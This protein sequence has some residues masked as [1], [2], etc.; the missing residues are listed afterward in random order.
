MLYLV[1]L[2]YQIVNMVYYMTE[3]SSEQLERNRDRSLGRL[4][5]KLERKFTQ[6]VIEA[7]EARGIRD[8]K[9][10]HIPVL[11]HIDASGSRAVEVAAKAGI[12]KQAAGKV[13]DALIKSGL[14]RTEPDPEDSRARI[15]Y[16]TDNGTRLL[17]AALAETDLV[18]RA[19][20]EKIGLGDLRILKAQLSQLLE[21]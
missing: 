13:I 15:V 20:A 10:A 19:W 9:M 8:L 17:E 5:L 3:A 14:V 2:I 12:S 1:N 7:L 21:D 18:E 11:G 16:F 6:A 4:L